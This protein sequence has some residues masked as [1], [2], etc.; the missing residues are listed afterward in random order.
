MILA[1]SASAKGEEPKMKSKTRIK[2]GA[3]GGWDANHNQTKTLKIKTRVKAGAG[4]GWEG[5]NHNQTR[6]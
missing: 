5:S 3:S 4:G 6:A 1:T 2:A